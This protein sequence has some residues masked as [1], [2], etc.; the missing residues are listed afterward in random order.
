M[1]FSDDDD[2]GEDVVDERREERRPSVGPHWRGDGDDVRGAGQLDDGDDAIVREIGTKKALVIALG[3]VR[4]HK[5]L[6][7]ATMLLL[8]IVMLQ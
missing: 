7:V 3:A 5:M 6:A 2:S 4:D 8:P 1:V